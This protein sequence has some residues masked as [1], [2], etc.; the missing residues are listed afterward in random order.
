[1]LDPIGAFNSILIQRGAILFVGCL[2]E[3]RTA[4]ATMIYDLLN[5]P[6]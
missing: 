2:G 4:L 1:M 3:N 6:R 5:D